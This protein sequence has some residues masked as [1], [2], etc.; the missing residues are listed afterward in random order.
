MYETGKKRTPAPNFTSPTWAIFAGPMRF[1]HSSTV[2]NP[3]MTR[4]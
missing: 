1:A 2:T 4:S 3:A